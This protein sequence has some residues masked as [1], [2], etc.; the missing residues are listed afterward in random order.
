MN[1]F[2]LLVLVGTIVGS[3][4]MIPRAIQHD[5]ALAELEAMQHDP[6]A[7]D[8]LQHFT[9]NNTVRQESHE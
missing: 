5:R 3:V 1:W 4:V 2:Y 9:D 6:L 8:E 7:E